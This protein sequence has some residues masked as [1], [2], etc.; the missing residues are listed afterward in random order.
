MKVS[1]SMSTDSGVS[2]RFAACSVRFGPTS[3]GDSSVE[4]HS[5]HDWSF[6]SDRTVPTRSSLPSVATL[7]TLGTKKFGYSTS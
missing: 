6:G 3:V 2:R 1:N 7:N 4:P 5:D